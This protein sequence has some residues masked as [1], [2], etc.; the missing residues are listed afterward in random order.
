MR[1]RT[2]RFMVGLLASLCA[3]VGQPLASVRHCNLLQPSETPSPSCI[4]GEVALSSDD[5]AFFV[6]QTKRGFTLLTHIWSGF[7]VAGGERVIG[8]LHS[9]GMHEIVVLAGPEHYDR[10]LD[11]KI[12]GETGDDSRARDAFYS[13]CVDRL[14]RKK[15]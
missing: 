1:R 10:T 14:A 13:R 8:P 7:S 12:E 4:E 6:V 11:V 5:C 9:P 2:R 3:G 15:P